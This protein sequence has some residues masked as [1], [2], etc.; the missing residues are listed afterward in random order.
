MIDFQILSARALLKVTSYSPIRGF[1][2]PS[3]VVLGEKLNM[4]QDVYFNDVQVKEFVVQSPNRMLVRIPDSQ[5]GEPLFS[6]KVYSDA[7]LNK[8]DA[9]LSLS[10]GTTSRKLEGIERL[11]Q[12]W[13]MVFLTTPGTDAF[14][15]QSGGGGRM[16]VGRTTDAKGKGVIADLAQAVEKTKNELIQKQSQWPG[17]PL[18]EKLLDSSVQG[19]S[20]DDQSST[21]LAQ[22][23]IQNMLGDQAEVNLKG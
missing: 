9:A 23:S 3:L 18:S 5:V 1:L 8:L 21:L 11:V 20:F 13:M 10:I 19:V 7:V 12:A 15:P 14:D 6:L 2:P 16:I 17:I 22:V 4:T